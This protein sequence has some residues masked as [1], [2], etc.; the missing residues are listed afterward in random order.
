LVKEDRTPET[1]DHWVFRLAPFLVFVPIFMLFVTIPFTG[2][3]VIR[4]LDLGIFYLVAFSTLHIVGM[5]MAGWGS[6]NK[7]ALLGGVRAA[8]QLVSYEL[9]LAFSILGVALLAQSLNLRTIV[10]LQDPIPYLLAQPL[11]LVVFLIASLAELSRT[12][13]DIPMAESE[14]VGGPMVEYSG[15]RW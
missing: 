11:G 4:N 2:L 6:D 10:E 12:P 5:L 7:Y 1:A 13:F 9:P 15:M 8:A 14:V 3:I